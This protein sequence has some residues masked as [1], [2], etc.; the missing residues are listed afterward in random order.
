MISFPKMAP[1]YILQ[2]YYETDDFLAQ[3]G[4]NPGGSSEGQRVLLDDGF[5][6]GINE[7]LARRRCRT[8]RFHEHFVAHISKTLC[9]LF[10]LNESAAQAAI[11]WATARPNR[12]RTTAKTQGF[13]NML[14]KMIVKTPASA[15][16]Q[17][18]DPVFSHGFMSLNGF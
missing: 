3:L 8:L 7:V 6:A 17:G 15:S 2:F 13:G 11:H 14:I 12:A 1:G 18:P 4:G 16:E 5:F 9:F 10:V